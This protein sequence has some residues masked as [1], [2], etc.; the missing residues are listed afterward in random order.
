MKKRNL[1]AY[2][3][4]H[5]LF[6]LLFALLLNT[7]MLA[8]CNAFASAPDGGEHPAK[9]NADKPTGDETPAQIETPAQVETPAQAETPAESETPEDEPETEKGINYAV[10]R[11]FKET[12]TESKEFHAKSLNGKTHSFTGDGTM[13]VAFKEGLVYAGESFKKVEYVK[14]KP[15]P[16]FKN[17]VYL[18]SKDPEK[19][20]P[21]INDQTLK[22]ISERDE[23]YLLTPSQDIYSVYIMLSIDDTVYVLRVY[24]A[25]GEVG[26]IITFN[27]NDEYIPFIPSDDKYNGEKNHVLKSLFEGGKD[28]PAEFHADTYLQQ[29]TLNW[30]YSLDVKFDKDGVF[31]LNGL[32]YTDVTYK[33][34]YTVKISDSIRSH[35]SSF[36]YRKA[37]KSA[38]A[39]TKILDKIEA[40]GE[41][42]VVNTSSYGKPLV[43]CSIGDTCF[44]LAVYGDEVIR[45]H[46]F[47]VE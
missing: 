5:I 16:P 31:Y 22:I 9:E 6:L 25:A 15:I 18:Y 36:E 33:T 4:Y 29:T 19:A 44:L 12:Q 23:Y 24:T 17:A 1:S 41:Y 27:A 35:S 45:T 37:D 30:E 8:G 14:G 34:D 26:D 32:S 11:L 20:L 21:E 47:T 3:K 7:A 40:L 42:Y 2:F 10:D 13:L 39:I 43:I 38:E 46:S 28:A